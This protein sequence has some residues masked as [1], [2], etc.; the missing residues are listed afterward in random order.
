MHDLTIL[1]NYL[2]KKGG[3]KCHPFDYYTVHYKG[4]MSSGIKSVDKV[5]DSKEY[6]KGHP[7]TFQQ[8]AFKVDKCWDMSVFL[9]SAGESYTIHCPSF[10]AKGGEEVYGHFDSFRIP[11]N[12]DLTYQIEILECE[13]TLAE[14]EKANIKYGLKPHKHEAKEKDNI[15]GSGVAIPTN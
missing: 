14:I 12:T 1:D 10:Y 11:P 9:M 8:G 4:F 5:F 3:R 2:V 15:I 13:P 6:R 7:L